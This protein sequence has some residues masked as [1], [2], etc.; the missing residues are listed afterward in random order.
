MPCIAHIISAF[1]VFGPEKT[2]INE[3]KWLISKG[4]K[5]LII[6]IWEELDVPIKKKIEGAGIN[7]FCLVSTGKFELQVISKLKKIFFSSTVNLVHSH[8]YKSDVYTSIAT[9]NTGIKT[10][11]TIHGWTSENY[12]VKLYEGLQAFIWKFYDK[13]YAVSQKY[14]DTAL[15]RGV[16]ESRLDL[17]Y[18]GIIIDSCFNNLIVSDYCIE[19]NNIINVG[20]VGRLSI[21]KG[22]QFY[23]QV[24][25]NVVKKQS[26][27]VFNIIGDGPEKARL[28]SLQ[29]KYQLESNLKFFG[30]IDN[31]DI[32]YQKLDIL[33][34]CSLR[35]G[36]PNVLLEA[37][38]N[39][40]PVISI[41]VGGV[42]EVID[43]HLNGGII[44]QERNIDKFAQAI[45]TL[46]NDFKLRDK[47]GRKGY[48]RII[49][50]FS[51]EKRMEK[52]STDYEAIIL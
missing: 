47:I 52:I 24:A 4:W 37:M 10:V 48:Q 38:L 23:L 20:I 42:P 6:N 43:S 12:K 49:N 36:L 45:L 17:L 35:E 46:S 40:I 5:C 26:N 28:E 25:A 19:Q 39:K 9:I 14:Y 32:I 29:K 34:I 31:M 44:I 15:L 51:F 50:N 2:T 18:N 13:V 22:H 8:G 16:S 27:I 21:E 41:N 11:T 3:C 1:D 7:Y 33:M 30:H